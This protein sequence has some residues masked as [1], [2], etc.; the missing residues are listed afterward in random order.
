M[1]DL[2]IIDLRSDTVTRPDAAMLAAMTRAE[3][4]DDGQEG[5][6]TT[7]RLEQV[8]AARMGHEAGLLVPSGT[9]GNLLAA[10]G[11]GRH[12]D[13]VIVERDAH[14]LNFEFNGLSALAG[15]LPVPLRGERGHLTP[16]GVETALA[17]AVPRGP[18]PRLVWL[19]NTANLAGGTVMTV[20]QTRA[21]CGLAHD[22]GLAVHLDGA[23]VF[24]AAVALG[25]PAAELAGSCDSVSFCL[26]KGLGCPV[27]SLL[28]G[29]GGFIEAAR[30]RRRQLGGT[31]RQSGLL[32]A[33]GLLA[34]ETRV[35]RMA[36]DH[37]KARW[38]ADRLAQVPGLHVDPGTV[39]T[40]IV[41]FDCD[42]PEWPARCRDAG[43]LFSHLGGGRCRFVTHFDVS[44]EQ[45]A[46]A[47]ERMA[48]CAA[49]RGR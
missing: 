16:E 27:G 29:P 2:D 48:A 3:L 18:G 46:E 20:E 6:P 30:Q 24:N 35:D 43:V 8:A 40:N 39:E 31:M 1:A 9:M 44:V 42:D 10:L 37:A 13:E 5:D 33:A 7:R 41:W 34:L 47:A 23:R 32:A 14:V 4:G 26:S 12:G 36:E 25:V 11:H 17:Q 19:E 28:C 21:V 45:V 15:L 49:D 22:R 38:L